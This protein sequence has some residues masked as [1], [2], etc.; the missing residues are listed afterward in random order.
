MTAVTINIPNSDLGFFKIV[1]A[2]MG[3]SME[4]ATIVTAPAYGKE[5]TLEKIDH[6]FKQFRQM[7]EGKLKGIDA[8]EL[9]N[10][11]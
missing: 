11:L 3:W 6:A 2:R 5:K 7:Q 4:E 9:L 8:E 10:E 1:M